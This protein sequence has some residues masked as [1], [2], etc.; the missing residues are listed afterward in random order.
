[1]EALKNLNDNSNNI[2]EQFPE[3][4]HIGNPILRTET[5]EVDLEQGMEI[6]TRLI[7]TLTKYREL[8]GV[9]RG[10]AAPQIGE[11]FSVFV[12]YV[13]DIFKIYMNPNIIDSSDKKNIYKENCLSS[14]HIWCDI[15]RPESV[16]IE[17]MN[18]QGETVQE[19]H[20]GFGA[21]LIQHEYDH[22]KGI[23]NVDRA[24]QGTV[25]YKFGDPTKE[26]LREI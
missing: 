15:V 24:E 3:I 9:G 12:T 14:S 6:G 2:L 25:E 26:V 11:G 4:T 8:T 20:S 17:Y 13:D 7:T 10:L 5:K 21:R 19:S 22:L 16:E 23:V 18:D 1:M